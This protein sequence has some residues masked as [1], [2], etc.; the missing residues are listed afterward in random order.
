MRTEF[1]AADSLEELHSTWI[2][3]KVTRFDAN[4]LTNI[5]HNQVPILKY[6]EWRVVDTARGYC[7]SILPLNVASTNQHITHQ[8]AVMMIAADYAGGVALSTLIDQVPIVGIH[9]Q[10]TDYGAYLWAGKAEVKWINPSC[11]DLIC[12]S[13]IEEAKFMQINKRFFQGSIVLFEVPIQMFNKEVLVA[14]SKITYWMQ[15]T[16]ALRRNAK[17]IKKIHPLFSH[18]QK[19]SANLIAGLRYLENK[20]G[21]DQALVTDDLAGEVAGTHGRILAHRFNEIVPQIQNMVASR[22][23]DCDQ[24]ILEFLKHDDIQIINIGIGLDTRIAR[25]PQMN[26]AKIFNLDLPVMLERRKEIFENYIGAQISTHINIPID[27]N[28]ENIADALVSHP[29]FDSKK[30][31]FVI[32]EGGSMYFSPSKAR[33]IF[34]SIA[35]L[36]KGASTQMWFDYVDIKVIDGTSGMD[37]VENFIDAIRMLGEPFVNGYSN[38]EQSMSDVGITIVSNK[39][40][41]FTIDSTDP[42]FG[43]YKFALVELN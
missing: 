28:E 37:V 33:E 34:S 19:T 20:K 11:D 36:F 42:I 2:D 17:D 18:K 22:T 6:L 21:Q 31:S 40:S 5:F 35:G 12:V 4:T 41:N 3:D 43:L 29:E 39:P 8:A 7:K 25:I 38:L 16:F 24:C 15:D 1:K 13:Q 30:K 23:K 26:K 10:R 9:P 27:L 32:W 14:E